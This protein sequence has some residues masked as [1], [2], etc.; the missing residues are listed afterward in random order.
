VVH[1]SVRGRYPPIKKRKRGQG[2]STWRGHRVRELCAWGRGMPGH[3]AR[4]WL[5]ASS[6]GGMV[7]WSKWWS[8]GLSHYVINSSIIYNL[9]S[10]IIDLSFGPKGLTT[11]LSQA[12]H[13]TLHPAWL[14]PTCQTIEPRATSTEPRVPVWVSRMTGQFSK[15]VSTVTIS[16]IIE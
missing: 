13:T 2:V 4:D 10:C 6:V 8:I 3:G 14:C 11:W 7:E 5:V 9:G 15:W 12:P 16:K 1:R